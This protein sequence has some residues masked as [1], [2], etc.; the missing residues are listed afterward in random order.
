VARWFVI[1]C[2]FAAGSASATPPVVTSVYPARQRINAGANTPV[3]VHFDQEIDP[4]SVTNITFRVFGRWSGPA[5][6]DFTV[7]GSTV[8]FAPAEPF[9]A[10]EWITVSLSKG[11]ENISGENMLK[12]YAWNFW[13]E[14]ADGSLTLSYDYRVTCRTTGE[15][16]VQ[17]YGAY[18]GDLNNDGWSDLVAPCEQTSD[19]RVFLSSS[20]TFSA[21]GMVKEALVNGFVPSPN[22]GADFDNDGE[23]DMVI[24]NTGGNYASILFG[25]GTGDFPSARKTSVLCGNSV[26][27]VGVGDF[28]GDGWD[29][30][31]TANRFGN[32]LSIVLNDGDG[33]F[34]A[35]V[36]KET[37][38]SNEYTIAIADANNDGLQDI[39]CGTFGS[40]YYMVVLLGDGNG[41]FTAQT[42]VAEGGSPW[43]SVVGDFNRD[44][45]VD[46]ASCN[47]NDSEIGV[48]YGNGSGGF[49]GAVQIVNCDQ[50]PLAIDA[51]DIDGDGD[52]ELVTSNYQG[53][54][55]NIFSYNFGNGTW[56]DKKVLSASSAGSC[57]I[58]HDRDRDGDLDLSGLDEIDD[59]I[60]FYENTGPASDVPGTPAPAIALLQNE[61]NPFNPTTSIRFD[62][63]RDAMLD[64]SVYD[65]SGAYVATLASGAYPRGAHHV[66][67]NGTDARGVR[68]ASGVYFYRLT[69]TGRTLTRKMVLLK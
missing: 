29:D 33:T 38:A 32:N 46:V 10:G 64:L 44:G 66:R 55:W 57:A 62:I 36:A 58:L 4:T 59:W 61:P 5:T 45:N 18:A 51:G 7:T 8:T 21:T 67:W 14:T 47:S 13:I 19:A 69:A 9:F 48:L 65:A 6:G 30:F 49:T 63:D 37:G 22:E 50:T 43:Q 42:P 56:G 60:Y 17:V 52:L 34:A 39:F 26:R 11:I 68:V 25:D 40:P 27:G 12:G 54:N 31:V 53:G 1:T 35:A 15:T 28:N 20:G 2:L 24:G 41:G 23:I 3:E 16:W